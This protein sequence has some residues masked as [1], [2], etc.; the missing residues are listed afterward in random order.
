MTKSFMI[1]INLALR[2]AENFKKN[3]RCRL[4]MRSAHLKARTRETHTVTEPVPA[5]PIFHN[6]LRCIFLRTVNI[7]FNL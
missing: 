2:L 3:L 1:T 4:E 6:T 7:F 5:A